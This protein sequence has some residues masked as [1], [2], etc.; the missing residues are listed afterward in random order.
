MSRNWNKTPKQK[1][2]P[3]FFSRCSVD[4]RGGMC[5]HNDFI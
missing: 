2:K 4:K 1:N 3:V 5:L